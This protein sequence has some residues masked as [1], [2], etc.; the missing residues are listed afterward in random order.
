M[1]KVQRNLALKGGDISTPAVRGAGT[2]GRRATGDVS[3]L[4]GSRSRGVPPLFNTELWPSVCHWHFPAC[5]I[6]W[7]P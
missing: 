1:E 3:V 2:S 7:C 4:A 6:R 5:Q